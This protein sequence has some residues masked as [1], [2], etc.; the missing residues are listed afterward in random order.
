M[1]NLLNGQLLRSLLLLVQQMRLLMEEEVEAVDSLL[2]RNDF[3]LQV[4]APPPH[5]RAFFS[6]HRTS[7]LGRSWRRSP[8][9]RCSSSSR[10]Q[11]AAVG[12]VYAD[13]TPH[14]ATLSRR[15]RHRS[16]PPTPSPPAPPRRNL[17]P[18]LI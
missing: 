1:S 16:L 7:P 4:R 18:E 10:S 2:K 3:N 11:S 13:P 15:Y 5:E 12:G 9:S 8:R 17:P 14:V 6:T